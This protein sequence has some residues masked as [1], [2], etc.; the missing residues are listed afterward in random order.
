MTDMNNL[1]ADV[2]RIHFVGIG[3][4]GMSPLAEILHAKGYALSGSD[5]NESD[6]LNRIRGEYRG[7]RYGG[8]YRRSCRR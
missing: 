1:L 7:R 3:G 8:I 2:R 5:H 6:N 4:S